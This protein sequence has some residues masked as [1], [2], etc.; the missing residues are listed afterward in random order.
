[1]TAVIEPVARLHTERS[2]DHLHYIWWLLRAFG[3]EPQPPQTFLFGQ[4]QEWTNSIIGKKKLDT[5][6]IKHYI[7]YVD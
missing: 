7:F 2:N 6:K 5:Y 3:R 1:M 4:P